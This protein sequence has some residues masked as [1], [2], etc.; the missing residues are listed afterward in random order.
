MIKI[1]ALI[2]PFTLDEVKAA[3][4]PFAVYGITI[5]EV[6]HYGGAAPLKGMYRGHEYSMDTPKMKLE[7][8]ASSL[9]T[10]E[11]VDALLHAARTKGPGDDGTVLIYEVA[12]AIRIRS[13]A[14]VQF[15]A[16]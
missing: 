15:A 2:Q 8:L 16:F 11:I 9:Q 14:R 13:G 12:D 6:F 5:S 3:L 1:E 4:R 7:I 10:D